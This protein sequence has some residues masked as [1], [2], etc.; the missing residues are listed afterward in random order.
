MAIWFGNTGSLR[1]VGKGA[2]AIVL[3]KDVLVKRQTA[4]A[5]V[6]SDAT[7]IAVRICTGLRRSGG[8]ELQIIGD[9]EI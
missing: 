2:V 4:R 9:E 3:I 1:N 5:A 8:I 6:D 7:V